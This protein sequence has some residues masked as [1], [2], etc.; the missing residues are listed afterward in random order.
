MNRSTPPTTS[1]AASACPGLDTP[2]AFALGVTCTSRFAA[3]NKTTAVHFKEIVELHIAVT[4]ADLLYLELELAEAHGVG[5][6]ASGVQFAVQGG[7]SEDHWHYTAGVRDLSL[8]ATYD[9]A[10]GAFAADG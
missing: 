5:N 6:W 10:V 9:A 2:A 7:S 4:G 3:D 8:L 1:A